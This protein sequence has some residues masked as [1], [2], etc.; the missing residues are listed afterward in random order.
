MKTHKE[1]KDQKI[2]I[3]GKSHEKGKSNLLKIKRKRKDSNILINESSIEKV[4]M[5]DSQK[6]QSN[7]NGPMELKK[8]FAKFPKKD[9]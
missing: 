9:E 1:Y 8:I 7:A 4:T 6:Y 2:R 3:S 5:E